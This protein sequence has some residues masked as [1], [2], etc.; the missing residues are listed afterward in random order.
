[1]GDDGKEAHKT[2]LYALDD[3]FFGMPVTV[4]V[5]PAP[6]DLAEWLDAPQHMDD[7]TPIWCQRMPVPGGWVYTLRTAGE[8]SSVFV[9]VAGAAGITVVGGAK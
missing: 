5:R 3:M 1:M 4:E 2:I 8:R 6:P 7:Q 9:P